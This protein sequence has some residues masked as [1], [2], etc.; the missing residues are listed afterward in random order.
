MRTFVD[1]NVVLDVLLERQPFYE[2]SAA[3]WTL[4]ELG[5]IEGVICPVSFTN[6]FYIVDRMQD[7]GKARAAVR[8]MRDIF[9]PSVC[10]GQVI[11]QAVD[12]E[13]SDFEDAIQYFSALHCSAA[14]LVTRNP[15][16]F[17]RRPA[18]PILPPEEF[19]TE[20]DMEP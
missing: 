7:R 12:S 6:V 1:T 10:D 14:C 19:L 16:G 15:T 4:A 9:E 2:R 13:I 3:V 8:D 11:N 20:L 5:R 17:P 18:L